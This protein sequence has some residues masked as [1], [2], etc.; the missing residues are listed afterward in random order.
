[1][2]DIHRR[3]GGSWSHHDAIRHYM[4]EGIWDTLFRLEWEDRPYRLVEIGSAEPT[5]SPIRIVT[6]LIGARCQPEVGNW[7]EVNIEE[8]PYLS[9]SVDILVADQVLEHVLN[10]G[11][12]ADE[13]WRVVKPGGL[14][15]IA[16]PYLHPIHK[17][18]LD[19]WRISPDGYAFLFPDFAWE[20]LTLG[21]W[22][23]RA[24]CQEVYA[25]KVSL[26]MTGDW[27]PYDQA[28]AILPSFDTPADDKHPIVI[29]WIGR[30]R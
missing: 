24:I 8:M 18:P 5:S 26:G 23:N 1:M 29:W 3:I 11:K 27:I 28:R 15:V 30:K 16:T 22:G 9:E 14:A 7:P 17:C 12:A 21:T 25:S 13:I 20:T 10:L 4:Y 2:T 6:S 19:C